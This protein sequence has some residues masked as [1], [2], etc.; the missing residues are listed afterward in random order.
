MIFSWIEIKALARGNIYGM[1]GSKGLTVFRDM[2]TRW[3][4]L[5]QQRLVPMS[6]R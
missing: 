2:I 5:D 6:L 4:T 1:L 3:I